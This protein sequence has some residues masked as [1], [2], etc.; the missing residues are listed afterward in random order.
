MKANRVAVV[1]IG[2]VLGIGVTACGSADAGDGREI[3]NDSFAEEDRTW[4]FMPPEGTVYCD[5]NGAVFFRTEGNDYAVNEAAQESGDYIDPAEIRRTG[6]ETDEGM[7]TGE[8]PLDDVIEVGE[9]LC[10]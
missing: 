10:D 8:E 6:E 4:P 5:E 2:A 3:S 7:V 9:E 1:A